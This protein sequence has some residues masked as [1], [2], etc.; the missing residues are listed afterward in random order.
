VRMNSRN[1][2]A[3]LI[4]SNSNSAD[5][6]QQVK[7]SMKSGLAAHTNKQ[8]RIIIA[9]RVKTKAWTALVTHPNRTSSCQI[10]SAG[11]AQTTRVVAR[12]TARIEKWVL[13]MISITMVTVRAT[14]TLRED[15]IPWIALMDDLLLIATR[16][17]NPRQST[18]EH[19][20]TMRANLMLQQIPTCP[21]VLGLTIVLPPTL[22]YRIRAN[23]QD[24]K[25]LDTTV[26][27]QPMTNAPS[28]Y[29]SLSLRPRIRSLR[30]PLRV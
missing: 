22:N 17:T 4:D 2:P 27:L 14:R 19:N 23:N 15:A 13:A 24:T 3:V 12:N 20:I 21:T 1:A 6:A 18:L 7:M 28:L 29:P 8:R 26:S 5:T 30:R 9:L 25:R 16:E 10:S 11:T